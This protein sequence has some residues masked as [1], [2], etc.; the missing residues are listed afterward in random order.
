VCDSA[1]GHNYEA[2]SL[3]GGGV[4]IDLMNLQELKI[5]GKANTMTVGAGYRLVSGVGTATKIRVAK[6]LLSV[7]ASTSKLISQGDEG[8][9]HLF[10]T[11]SYS[12]HLLVNTLFYSTL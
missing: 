2:N 11:E 3:V 12:A 10:K 8:C 7:C 6:Q 1:G 5:D 9:W 4:V